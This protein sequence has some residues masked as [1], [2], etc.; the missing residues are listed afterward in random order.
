MREYLNDI[1][2]LHMWSQVAAVVFAV[3]ADQ[4]AGHDDLPSSLAIIRC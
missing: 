2:I 4:F 3:L 1:M